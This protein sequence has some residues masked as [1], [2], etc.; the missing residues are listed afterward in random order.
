MAPLRT[1][2][3][4]PCFN[5][6]ATVPGLVAR[7]RGLGVDVLVGDAPE[8]VHSALIPADAKPKLRRELELMGIQRS[9]LFPD[10][11]NLSRDITRAE[12][13]DARA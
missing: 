5:E 1:L 2:V 4:L 3:V 11:E 6:A 10:L 13:R 8:L 7:L 12:W 9:S